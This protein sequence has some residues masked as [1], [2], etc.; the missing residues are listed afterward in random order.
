MRLDDPIEMARVDDLVGTLVA[1]AESPVTL[2]W[3]AE[4]ILS[5]SRESISLSLHRLIAAGT[6]SS[7]LVDEVPM[8]ESAS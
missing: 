8:Y 1:E 4:Q 6:V 7:M 5:V 2:R 3:L